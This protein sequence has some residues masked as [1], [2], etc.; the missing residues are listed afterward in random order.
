MN[1]NANLELARQQGLIVDNDNRNY[2]LIEKFIL[3]PI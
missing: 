1:R 3:I 2:I